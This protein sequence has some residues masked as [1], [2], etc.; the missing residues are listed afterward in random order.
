MESECVG[1]GNTSA[2][3]ANLGGYGE[4]YGHGEITS[5]SAGELRGRQD[6]FSNCS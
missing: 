5:G 4:V 6:N 3:C 2:E 1:G